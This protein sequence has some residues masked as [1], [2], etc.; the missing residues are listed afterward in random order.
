M[1]HKMHPFRSNITCTEK[2]IISN[3][4]ISTKKVN[5]CRQ[6]KI[7]R[8]YACFH[9]CT[10]INSTKNKISELQMQTGIRYLFRHLVTDI[11]CIYQYKIH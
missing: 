11:I 8:T 5:Q 6:K 4:L 1:H 2:K 7:C 9:N 10:K 3:A